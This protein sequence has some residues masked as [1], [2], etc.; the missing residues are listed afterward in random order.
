[1]TLFDLKTTSSEGFVKYLPVKHLS[2]K[3][4]LRILK[5]CKNNNQ[6][7][8]CGPFSQDFWG[9][10]YNALQLTPKFYGTNDRSHKAT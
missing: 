7:P 9:T 4:M 2:L 6:K 10:P 3:D 5:E 1:M 8:Y